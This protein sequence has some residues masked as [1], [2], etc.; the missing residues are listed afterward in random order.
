[1]LVR[2]R[3][4][5]R[6]GRQLL[7]DLALIDLGLLAQDVEGTPAGLIGRDLGLGELCPEFV[8]IPG[9]VRTKEPSRR[10]VCG[11]KRKRTVPS[12][13]WIPQKQ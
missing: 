1:M 12:S 7:D 5:I 3:L 9:V 13:R 11:S 6:R 2:F 10:P 8:G 4:A